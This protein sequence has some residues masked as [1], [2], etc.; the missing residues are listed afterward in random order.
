MWP[1]GDGHRMAKWGASV[2][3]LRAKRGLFG[4]VSR[5][6]STMRSRACLP[7]S[8]RLSQNLPTM[9]LNAHFGE[10][11]ERSREVNQP[12]QRSRQRSAV[13]R[14]R[15]LLCVTRGNGTAD[16]G[17][18][19]AWREHIS[20]RVH[21]ASNGLTGRRKL[22]KRRERTVI[23]LFGHLERSGGGSKAVHV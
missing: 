13:V 14:P 7:T 17:S 19:P 16:R 6:R 18:R 2:G 11:T 20:H 21:S 3:N 1:R 8:T 23:P 22:L 15:M 5:R 12:G 4:W 9:G 10:D